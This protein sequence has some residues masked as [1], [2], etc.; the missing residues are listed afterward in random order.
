MTDS[1]GELILSL[2]STFLRRLSCLST[3]TLVIVC[4]CFRS[5]NILTSLSTFTAV[6][7]TV[8]ATGANSSLT[9]SLTLFS[10]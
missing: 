7:S 2:V 3:L 6:L 8:L 1:E 5:T 4:S 9:I 10:S